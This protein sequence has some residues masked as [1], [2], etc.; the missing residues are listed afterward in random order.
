MSKSTLAVLKSEIRTEMNCAYG[1]QNDL[2]HLDKT[3]Y[4]AMDDKVGESARESLLK[5]RN[6]FT[7][8]TDDGLSS[9]EMAANALSLGYDKADERSSR[10]D[11]LRRRADSIVKGLG[12]I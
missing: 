4:S 5:I 12:E 6:R 8:N 2:K 7:L 10:A 9:A 1:A 11:E 3:I